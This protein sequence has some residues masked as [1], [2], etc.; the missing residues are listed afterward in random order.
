MLINEYYDRH[1]YLD[2][3]KINGPE[4]DHES[5][6]TGMR[7]QAGVRMKR[8]FSRKQR[9]ALTSTQPRPTSTLDTIALFSR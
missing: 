9:R 8:D 5:F 2:T 7:K 3:M 1:N 6:V 4:A